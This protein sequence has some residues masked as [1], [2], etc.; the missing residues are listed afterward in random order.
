LAFLVS[1]L[2][3]LHNA[4]RIPGGIIDIRFESTRFRFLYIKTIHRK[5]SYHVCAIFVLS[6]IQIISNILYIQGL[7]MITK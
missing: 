1:G 5:T 6:K 3:E 4:K 2:V 7:N